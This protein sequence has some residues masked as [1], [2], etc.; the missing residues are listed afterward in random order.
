[1]KFESRVSVAE[2]VLRH[3]G[4]IAEETLKVGISGE[5]LMVH[6]SLGKRVLVTLTLIVSTGARCKR[7]ASKA[8]RGLEQRL[9]ECCDLFLA[10]L[11]LAR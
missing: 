5:R 10:F 2:S 3:Q 6:K 11:Y 7:G 9:Q 8:A 4:H 1:L